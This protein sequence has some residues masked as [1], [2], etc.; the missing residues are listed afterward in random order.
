VSV[1]WRFNR[2]HHFVD[3]KPF[4]KNQPIKKQGLVFENKIDNYGMVLRS[5]DV[6]Q[7]ARS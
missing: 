2:W 6:R 4:K 5:I 7:Y 3:Y 1:V